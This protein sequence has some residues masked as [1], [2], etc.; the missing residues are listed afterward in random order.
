MEAASQ[1]KYLEHPV[2]LGV[3]MFKKKGILETAY[4]DKT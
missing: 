1:K 2:R 4:L 3:S